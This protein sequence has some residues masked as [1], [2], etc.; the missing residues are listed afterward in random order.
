MKKRL[1]NDII[2]FLVVWRTRC[3][4]A[5]SR[6]C[7]NDEALEMT[8]HTATSAKRVVHRTSVEARVDVDDQI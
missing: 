1:V 2:H 4:S 7:V 8:Q 5:S 3:I 6:L